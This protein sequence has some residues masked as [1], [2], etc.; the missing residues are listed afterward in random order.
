MV[1]GPWYLHECEIIKEALEYEFMITVARD[2][3]PFLVNSSDLSLRSQFFEGRVTFLLSIGSKVDLEF[4]Y[5]VCR[6]DLGHFQ[7]GLVSQSHRLWLEVFPRSFGPDLEGLSGG[8][9]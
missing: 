2:W 7:C 9:L 3:F 6:E 1:L 4:V 5:P 8:L